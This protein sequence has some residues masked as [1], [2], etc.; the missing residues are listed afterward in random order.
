MEY[1]IHLESQISG[2][3]YML[4]RFHV[5]GGTSVG[6]P[7]FWYKKLKLSGDHLYVIGNTFRP[8]PKQLTPGQLIT[9]IIY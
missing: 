5:S 4:K 7:S 1:A 9:L 8:E 3:N 2:K 6:R